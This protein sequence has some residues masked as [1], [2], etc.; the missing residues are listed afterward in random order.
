MQFHAYLVP[1]EDAP[2][3]ADWARGKDWFGRWMPEI[4]DLH[5]LLLGE[6]PDAPQWAAADGNVDWWEARAQGPQPASL[7]HC[8][9]WYGCTG[10]SRDA[11]AD[12]ETR[13]YVPS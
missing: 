3:V 6:H 11:S 7:W 13:G 9:A 1:M 10:T 2:A 4:P 12:D 8:A 5:N